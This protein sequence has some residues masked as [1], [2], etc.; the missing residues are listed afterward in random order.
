MGVALRRVFAKGYHLADLQADVVAGLVVAVV[1]LP[2]S[3][4]L[5][6]AVGVPP[7]HGVTSAIVAGAAAA[8]LGGA[9]FQ[10]TGPSAGFVLVLAPIVEKHGLG[11][12]LVAGGMAGLVLVALGL[13]RLGELVRFI[14][15]PVTMGFT[16]GIAIVMATLQIKDLLGLSTGPLP[17]RFDQKLLVFWQMRHT[18]DPREALVGGV[19]LLLLASAGRIVRR[20][21]APLVA[22][23]VVSV[24]VALLHR[25]APSFTVVT[26]AS[27]F[28][29]GLGSF[30]QAS[31]HGATP[32]LALVTDLVG[33]AFALAMLASIES[34]LS[35]VIADGLTRTKH[36]PNAELVGLG[37]ANVL[38][39]MCG[40]IAATGALA[41]TGTN[42]RAGARSPFAAL[43]H[44]LVLLVTV[45][46]FGPVVAQ[47]PIAALAALLLVVAWNMAELPSLVR[48]VQLAPRSDL[49]VLVT[50]VLLAVFVDMVVAV[51]V[52]FTLAAVLFMR[53]MAEL[54]ESRLVSGGSDAE[55]HPPDG[56]MVYEINGPLFF[57]AAQKAMATLNTVRTAGTRV[58][59]L[60]LGNV[61]VVD[62][63]GFVALEN[64]IAS[65]ER[66]G[67][68][69]V[70]AGPLPRPHR[71]FDRARLAERFPNLRIEGTLEAALAR[72]GTPHGT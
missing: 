6:V 63:T 44:A 39:A 64:A 57:G 11:G 37:I 65:A 31:H 25:V 26:I 14:P 48:L 12:A 19:T 21:P 3:M 34:L 56:V 15:Y 70:L 2:L 17:A 7:R 42:I 60:H 67:L 72:A 49:F 4:A 52:G 35:G 58:L 41:R 40:G 9:K 53:R 62:L 55:L 51:A 54:T 28:G 61:P 20:V 29:G 1:A 13:A 32:S 10:V 16:T 8:L 47:V 27:R 18:I 30:A 50:C 45:L 22:L 59:V 38:S 71:V 66:S 36:D 23:G 5:A 24:G 69:V 46:L 33:P 68:E 43:T